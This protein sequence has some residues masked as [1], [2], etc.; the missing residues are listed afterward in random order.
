MNKSD[1]KILEKVFAKEIEGGVFQSKSK[2]ISRLE[3]EGYVQEVTFYIGGGAL[4]KIKISGYI[5][6]ILGNYTYC[7]SDLCKEDEE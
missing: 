4:G 6:T 5:L 7:S 1:L 3:K 2:A